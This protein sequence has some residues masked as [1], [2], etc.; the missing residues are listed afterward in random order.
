[1]VFRLPPVDGDVGGAAVVDV[2]LILVSLGE[3]CSSMMHQILY[4]I[5]AINISKVVD[6]QHCPDT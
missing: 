3:F 1:V 4:H 5:T 2:E 6:V